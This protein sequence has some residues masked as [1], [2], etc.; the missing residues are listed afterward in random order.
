M[1]FFTP[2]LLASSFKLFTTAMAR[3]FTVT[4]N[5][6]FTIWPAINTGTGLIPNQPTGW[7]A[8]ASSSVSFAVPNN[9][10]IGRIWA[11]RNCDFNIL[12]P[13]SCLDGGCPS[14]LLLCDAAP[15]SPVTVADF[16]LSTSVN[17]PD[18]YAVS[19]VDGFNLPMR[20][21][22]SAGCSGALCGVDLGPLC[23]SYSEIFHDILFNLCTEYL[24][25]PA[26][27]KGPFDSTGFPVG[28][29]SA[30]QANLAPDPNND[31]NCCTGKYSTATACSPST[32][33]YYS[34][35]KS[36][37]PTSYVYSKD[38]LTAAFTCSSSF[39]ADYTVTFC[40]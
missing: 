39:Q 21:G 26:P 40:P 35:F 27:L 12:G 8:P 24:E 10:S 32:V 25:G 2:L 33:Q 7:A 4:N 14:G 16:Q 28:C 1:K 20:I 19:L 30:C 22:N 36:L 3:T 31:P 38:P 11:R 17:I 6:P 15:V 13:N 29:N 5:C 23:Q 37:C 9:W 34:F 18:L